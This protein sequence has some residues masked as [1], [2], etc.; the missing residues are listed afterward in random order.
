[1]EV[2]I[3]M[4]NIFIH[5]GHVFLFSFSFNWIS[6]FNKSF[7]LLNG[8]QNITFQINHFCCTSIL[9][10]IF[11]LIYIE[12]LSVIQYLLQYI[13]F[14]ILQF[15]FS[16]LNLP[17]TYRCFFFLFK[18][19]VQPVEGALS[20]A[21]SEYFEKSEEESTDQEN[22]GFCIFSHFLQC[23]SLSFSQWIEN[24]FLW[25]RILLRPFYFQM[26][27]D[28]ICKMCTEKNSII[29]F[30]LNIKNYMML[31]V[32]DIHCFMRIIKSLVKIQ[33]LKKF[34]SNH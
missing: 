11:L 14:T 24:C 29:F 25:L 23:S 9:H 19:K 10:L 18:L 31:L 5:F 2:L 8:S 34:S 22:K 20:Q 32:F 13:L 15:R 27:I 1:M 17:F 12:F 28:S 4:I 26:L 6:S 33:K 30:F 7:Y 21:V 16:Y 3:R